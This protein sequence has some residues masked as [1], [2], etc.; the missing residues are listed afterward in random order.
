[1]INHYSPTG[2]Y[3]LPNLVGPAP[4]ILSRMHRLLYFCVCN[5]TNLAISLKENPDFV[6]AKF[7][8][9]A[10]SIYFSTVRVYSPKAIRVS[11]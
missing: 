5:C 9:V 11:V 4:R 7:T 6:N 3:L 1:M 8:K 2:L 10:L